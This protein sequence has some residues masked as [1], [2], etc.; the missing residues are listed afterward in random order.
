MICVSIADINFEQCIEVIQDC[1]MAEIRLDKLDF[2]EAQIKQLFSSGKKHIATFRKADKSDA[3]R[4][5]HLAMAIKAG[6]SYV[7]I[8]VDDTENFRKNVFESI[9]KTHCKAI[10]SYHNYQK[11]PGKSELKNIVK[12]CFAKGAD[13]VKIACTVNHPFEAARLLSLYD[14]DYARPGN[15]IAIGMGELGKITRLAATFLG[16]PFTYASIATDKQTAAGQYDVVSMKRI[17]NDIV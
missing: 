7:D 12:A 10:I 4:N 14:L 8:D 3:H 1:E 11:T 9:N 5:R 16:A 15:I 6:A 13:I 17:L 2:S